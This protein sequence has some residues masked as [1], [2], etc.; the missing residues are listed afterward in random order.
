MNRKGKVLIS[1]FSSILI[2]M[3]CYIVFHEAG[4]SLVA[5]ICGAE[6]TEF[7]II[8]AHMSYVGGSFTNY[9]YALLHAAGMLMPVVNSFIYMLFY[10][11]NYEN[12]FYRIFSAL[13]AT[14]PFFSV[15]AWMLVP[16]LYI[17]GKAPENDDVTKFINVSGINPLII[18]I[19]AFV[20]FAGGIFLA[21]KKKI[22]INYWNVCR[23]KG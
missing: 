13:F 5:V 4:H 2:V 9:T 3:F 6:I 22:I 16:V 15:V 8:S 23:G 18:C 1:L 21:W 19:A 11:C 12:I 20:L 17:M 7:S 14:V 10:R